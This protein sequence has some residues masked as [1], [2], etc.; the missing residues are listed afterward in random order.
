[1]SPGRRATR[2]SGRSRARSRAA[3]LALAGLAALAA[4]A[5]PAARSWAQAAR[6]STA[7]DS[8]ARDSSATRPA[9]RDSSARPAP[10]PF[11]PP[12]DSLP[13]DDANAVLR[14]IPEPLA[15]EEVVPPDSSQVPPAPAAPDTSEAD[16]VGVPVPAPTAPLG[17]A[18]GGPA[19]SV[20]SD[21]LASAAPGSGS[22]AP[23]TPAAPPARP[24]VPAAPDTCWRLQIAAPA[25]REE[26]EGRRAAAVS[27]LLVAF[28]IESEQG[29]HKVRSRDCLTRAA[30]EALRA[31][32]VLSGFEGAFLVRLGPDGKPVPAAAP[33]APAA[34]RRSG[35]TRKPR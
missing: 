11:A 22:T 20:F 13:G 31:R 8:A 35:G 2:G 1:M 7:R 21:S 18:P 5:V 27:Q 15:P 6:D 23:A 4:L 24:G 33:P 25:D 3:A 10:P 9:A 28:A 19:R 17:E 30:A 26:A 34:P 16:T 14:T 29:R 12:A 32:A